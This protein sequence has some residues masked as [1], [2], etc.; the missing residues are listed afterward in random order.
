MVRRGGTYPYL[1]RCVPRYLGTSEDLQE[2]DLPAPTAHLH[3][4]EVVCCRRVGRPS[5]SGLH[6]YI[7]TYRTCP[8][9]CRLGI[10]VRCLSVCPSV[11]PAGVCH[12]P[13]R[14]SDALY[15]RGLEERPSMGKSVHSTPVGILSETT[16][17]STLSARQLG[18]RA[19]PICAQSEPHLFHNT[20]KRGERTIAKQQHVCFQYL[21]PSL[22]PTP[23]T[24]LLLHIARCTLHLCALSLTTCDPPPYSP[25]WSHPTA[26]GRVAFSRL[27]IAGCRLPSRTAR[28]CVLTRAAL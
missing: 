1:S 13:S 12:L 24:A 16:G 28:C 4:L 9:P 19:H 21:N 18:G 10:A 25:P 5:L 26:A 20:A 8:P 6:T 27:R 2:G 3:T 7:P 15:K 11:S 14:P 23:D 17:S 22:L